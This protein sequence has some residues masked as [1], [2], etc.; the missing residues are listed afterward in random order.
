M[1]L[2]ISDITNVADDIIQ[3]SYKTGKHYLEIEI[4][5][6]ITTKGMEE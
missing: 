4:N 6:N 3:C 1:E 5:A 2:L